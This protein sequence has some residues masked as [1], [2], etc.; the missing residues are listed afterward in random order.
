MSFL[1][2]PIINYT[3]HAVV[4]SAGHIVYY[5]G[6]GAWWLTKRAIWGREITP[7]ERMETLAKQQQQILTQLDGTAN[8]EDQ[9][10]MMMALEQE[11]KE[12]RELKAE[13]QLRKQDN[14]QT[15]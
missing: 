12:L 8:A 9:Q 3:V 7:E 13:L 15:K 5:A 10:K 4:S 14:E 6:A 1:V 11:L 2:T